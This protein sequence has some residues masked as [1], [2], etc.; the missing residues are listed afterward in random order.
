M[1]IYCVKVL[2][3]VAEEK[4][5]LVCEKLNKIL[6][7]KKTLQF[8]KLNLSPAKYYGSKDCEVIAH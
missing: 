8:F 1:T 2:V 5:G 7:I 4:A 6:F 3:S